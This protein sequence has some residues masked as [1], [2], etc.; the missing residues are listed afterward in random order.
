MCVMN[1]MGF[2]FFERRSLAG[3]TLVDTQETYQKCD[4]TSLY[5]QSLD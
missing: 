2:H 5:V 3:L 1:V 4:C